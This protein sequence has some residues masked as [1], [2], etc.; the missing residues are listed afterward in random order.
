MPPRPLRP[1]RKMNCTALTRDEMGYC[2]KHKVEYLEILK[3]QKVERDKRYDENVRKTRDKK[4][5]EFYKS[6]E[7]ERVK[8]AILVRD[9]G[10]CQWCY[11]QGKLKS[12]D[13]VHHIVELKQD[14]SRRLDPSNLVSLCHECH[15]RHHGKG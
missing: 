4:Y 10:L 5:H 15:N 2:D 3:K 13:V 7:W 11:K 14:W 12:A 9:K 1:C 6:D 8:K